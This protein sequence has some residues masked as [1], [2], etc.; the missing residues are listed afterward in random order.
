MLGMFYLFLWLSLREA[1]KFGIIDPNV[2]GSGRV[3]PNFYESSFMAY[4]RQIHG[5][6]LK[7]DEISEIDGVGWFTSLGYCPKFIIF[8][9]VFPKVLAQ[10]YDTTWFVFTYCTVEGCHHFHANT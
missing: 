7:S 2:G 1:G 4:L 6:S 10:I 3:V 9:G 5:K 8:Y